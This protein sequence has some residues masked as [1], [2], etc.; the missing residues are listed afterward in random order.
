MQPIDPRAARYDTPTMI[1]HWLTALLVVTQWVGAQTI[2]YFPK[3]ALRVDAR[4]MHIVFGL[5]LGII[6]IA[7]IIWRSTRGR[8]LPPVGAGLIRWIAKATHWGLYMLVSAMI[9]VGIFLA[10]TRGDSIFN[11]VSIPAFDPGNRALAEQVQQ[12]HAILGW[13]ILAVAGFHAAAALIHR[14]L[15]HDGVLGRMLPAGWVRDQ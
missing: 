4:S 9:L 11:L 10:W 2:D 13:T 8:Q 6:L 1:F 5:V 7:R 15:W 12:I 3:G 14:Y